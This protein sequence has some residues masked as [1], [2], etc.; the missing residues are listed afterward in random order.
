MIR[1]ITEEETKSHQS[2]SMKLA[3]TVNIWTQYI[4]RNI[5][6]FECHDL[7]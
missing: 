4:N 7:S 3:Q 2:L 1:P 6:N 5:P